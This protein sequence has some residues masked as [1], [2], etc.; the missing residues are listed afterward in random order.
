MLDRT[1]TVVVHLTWF[2]A[3]ASTI[4][5]VFANKSALLAGILALTTL[6]WGYS[7]Y[8]ALDLRRLLSAQLYRN[9]AL[10]LGLV[11]VAWAGFELA[12]VGS[13]TY[14]P[15]N[16]VIGDISLLTLVIV[17]VV[18]F[19]FTDSSVLAA[20]KS[21]P[22]YRDTFRWRR[23]RLVVW[24]V[25]VISLLA[26]LVLAAVS[27]SFLFSTGL[28][29]ILVFVPFF[30]TFGSALVLLPVSGRRSRDKTLRKNLQWFGLFGASILV[31]FVIG[32]LTNGVVSQAT[33]YLLFAVGSYCIYR[34]TKSL[35]PLNRLAPK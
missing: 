13:V 6:M 12:T 4:V 26:L 8:W 2:A 32:I 33:F 19:Y 10:A 15:G 24:P 11:A 23:L 16:S 1:E 20:R 31:T 3:I 28:F 21:D 34:S 29:T 35:A 27:L 18:T 9:Q 17:L 30:G 14:Y 25:I 22:L 7:V 5:G